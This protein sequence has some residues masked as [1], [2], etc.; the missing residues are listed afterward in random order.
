MPEPAK[1]ERSVFSHDSTFELCKKLMIYK[2][3]GSN[4]FINYSLMG[5]NVAYKVF[6][7]RLT[8][9]AIE[10]T[11]ASLFTGGVTVADLNKDS[12]KLEA[13]GT[14]C[15]GCY[16]VEGVRDAKNSQLDEFLDFSLQSIRDIAVSGQESHFA[17]KLTAYISTD[18]MEKLNLAQ[19]RFVND[20]LN[21]TFDASNDS[22]LSESQLVANLAAV[23]ITDF[24]K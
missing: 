23:G 4:V 10:S 2:M 19:Y 14:G 21:V 22:V 8:N 3:M 18:L 17:L 20:V 15:I 9:F 12:V 16:V 1:E 6:G 5:I 7:K 13:R 11:A 24:S